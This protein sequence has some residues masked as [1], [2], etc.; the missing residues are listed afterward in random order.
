MEPNDH[1]GSETMVRTAGIKALLLSAL[2]FLSGC[3]TLPA[4]NHQSAPALIAPA[5]PYLQNSRDAVLT[6]QTWYN[7]STGL[8]TT[9]GWW[10]SANAITVLVDYARVSES[11]EY[12]P[13][14]ANT[15]TAAQKT[16]Q[17]FLNKYYDDE[18]WWAL[19][20]IDAYDLT[21]NKDYLLMAESIFADMAGAWDDTCGGGIWWSKDRNY[22]NAIANELFL[23]VAAHLANRASR[24]TRS[25][26][27]GWGNRE[28]KWFQ[29][30]G[31]INAKS[32]V[33]DGLTKGNGELGAPGCTNNGRTTWTYNQGVVLGGLVELMG[34]NHDPDLRLTAQKIATAAITD[35][36]DEN[37]IL[38]DPCEPK[39]GAD[40]VQF[41]G[42][43]VRNLVL[44]DKAYPQEA[45]ESFVDKNADAVWRDARGPNFQLAQRWSGPFDSGNAASQASALDAL[46][47]AA[48]RWGV[49][50]ECSA[51]SMQ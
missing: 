23:S 8:Y 12:N 3:A 42:I 26:Y 38:H 33:N 43:F 45:Y 39:C 25:Q 21:R 31:M 36:T 37:G 13:V 7:P 11:T 15:F 28:W 44:L 29:T 4:R 22:K 40:A 49:R 34:A 9:T 6:L 16:S 5:T 17:G 30:S 24:S 32:L 1:T 10:N 18:G 46:V 19:A 35:L 48:T 51:A 14:F 50:R 2:A 27:L 20:W 41:K 47:G